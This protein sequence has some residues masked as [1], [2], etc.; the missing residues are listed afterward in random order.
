MATVMMGTKYIIQYH[1]TNRKDDV[2][3]YGTRERLSEKEIEK[4][5][6]YWKVFGEKGKYPI[7]NVKNT[8]LIVSL[9]CSSIH[10]GQPIK[11]V[12]AL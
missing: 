10:Q 12:K 2:I 5:Y 3:K 7:N 1:T 6:Y 8:I 4:L 9:S 11:G